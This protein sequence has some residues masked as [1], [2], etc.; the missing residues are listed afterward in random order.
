MLAEL[1]YHGLDPVLFYPVRWY[2]L[3]YMVGFLAGMWI[4]GRLARRKFFPGTAQQAGD[5]LLWLVLGVVVGGR[6]GF[7]LFY[8]QSLLLRPARL[9]AIWEGGL[10]F[11]GGLLGVTAAAALFSRKHRLPFW[12]VG[13][14]LVLA[15]TPG[16]FC[17]RVAN[18]INGELFGRHASEW[19]PWAMRFPRSPEALRVLRASELLP[20]VTR[21]AREEE[22][23]IQKILHDGTWEKVA[24]HVPLRHPS[25]LYEALGEGLLLGLILFAAY[26]SARRRG[27]REPHGI[28]AALFLGGYGVI[29]FFLEYFREPDAP[30]GFDFGLFSRGQLLCAGMVAAAAALAL[31]SR[32]RASA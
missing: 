27:A 11:H 2:G 28:Y 13:D 26:R 32:R 12:R 20:L 23:A 25:Q 15:A 7:V 17:V 18:F 9:V 31:W 19:V 10:S 5:L 1:P 30:I 16:I 3:G 29:R 24:E 6:L 8:D 22:L 4:L 21:T 14:C